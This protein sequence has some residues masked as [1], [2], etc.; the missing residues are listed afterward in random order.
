MD[1]NESI[2]RNNNEEESCEELAGSWVIRMWI[3]N[4]DGA[5]LKDD[6]SLRGQRQCGPKGDKPPKFQRK[7][8]IDNFY[9]NTTYA[10]RNDVNRR[11]MD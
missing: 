10:G 3:R 8:S 5:V 6:S 2:L 9:A 1:S 7:I 11:F 4:G